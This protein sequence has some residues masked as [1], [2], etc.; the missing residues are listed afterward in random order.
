MKKVLVTG[1][2]GFIGSH[3]CLKLLNRGNKVICV[4]NLSTGSQKNITPFINHR[5]FE[6]I[7]HDVIDYLDLQADEIYSLACPA[8]PVQYLKDPVKTIKTCLMGSINMLELA[9]RTNSKILLSSTSE[10]YGNP[11]A[12]PQTEDYFG[13]VNFTGPR[14]CYDEGK[15]TS[16]TLF[17]DYNRQYGVP[18]KVVR[19]FN[20]YGPGMAENDGRVVSN[21]ITQALKNEAIT[22]YGDGSQSRSF[23]YISDM[24]DGFLKMMDMPGFTGPVNLGNPCE[25]TILELAKIIIRMTGSSSRVK[26]KELPVDD[27]VR[28]KPDIHLSESVLGWHPTVDFEDG[29]ERTIQYFRS[30]LEGTDCGAAR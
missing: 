30:K 11:L 24:V 25:L 8:S 19:I 9:K 15:R 3:L 7:N 13:N 14:A 22:I 2:A 21:F 17:F 12:H 26:Y 1:G 6:F 4:D 29:L 23:C 18:V 5:H 20:T 10:V 27:P 16:E 28:R